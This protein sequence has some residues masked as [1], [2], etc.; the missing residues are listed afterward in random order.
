MS[1]RIRDLDAQTFAQRYGCDR[2]VATVLGNRL[3]YV[4]EHVCQRLLSCAF[5]PLLR[6]FYDFAATITGAPGDGYPTPVVSKTFMAFTGTM[7]ESVRNTIEEYGPQRLQPGDVIIANDPYRI[8]T[9]VNDVLFC[10]PVFHDGLLVAF[11]TIKAHQLDIGGAVPG[12]FSINKTSVYENGLVLSPRALMQAGEPV[13]ETWS[14]FIDNA[15]FAP[16]LVRDMQTLCACL[17]LGE[18]LLH[19]SLQRYGAAALRGAMAY[20]VDADAERMT[21]A[22]ARLP[23]GVWHGEALV[24]CDGMDDSE[25]YPVRCTITKRG[26]RMEI[27]LSGT[28]RQART[29]INGSFLDVKATVGVALKFM[30]DPNGRFTSGMY[31]PV[32]LVIPDGAICSALPPDGV[33]FAYGESTNAL[34]LAMLQAMADALA[35]DAVAGDTGSPNLHTALGFHPDGRLWIAV[36]VAGGE[37]GPWGATRAGDADSLSKFYQA[38]SIDT[39]IEISE[40]DSPVVILRREYVADSAGPGFNRGGAAVL[41]DSTFLAPASHNLITLRLKR[42]TGKGVR[43][44]GDGALGGTWLWKPQAGERVALQSTGAASYRAAIRVAGMLD[45]QTGLAGSSGT[46]HWP[47][48]DKDWAT[49]PGAVWRYVTNG[50]GG[51]GDPWTR[52]PQRVLRDVRDGYVTQ[53]GAARDYGV[54]V[55][56]DPLHDPEGLSVDAAATA[57]LRAARG[58]RPGAAAT[59]G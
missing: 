2:F 50:G 24:D 44:G 10:R 12:G 7:T 49:P 53:V 26:E 46:Y 54:V 29:S 47:G 30:L 19:A 34:L 41:K 40:L 58:I 9:H 5:S 33:I 38:N 31:R 21:Q 45:E 16:V 18:Q 11:I 22:L 32:D 13:R 36:G 23:D 56:G 52:E 35:E 43:G 14:L 1:T 57:A 25:E 20:V 48:R 39:P 59:T 4:L 28:A 15:R 55:S 3:E 27:D 17:D 37:A 42:A 51:W 8:G 6:D